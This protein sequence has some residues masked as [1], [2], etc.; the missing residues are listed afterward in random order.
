MKKIK[1]KQI[2]FGGT[3]NQYIKGNGELGELD[4]ISVG[5]GSTSSGASLPDG[6]Y[7]PNALQD[8]DGN[9]YG[10]VVIGNQVWLAENYRCTKLPTGTSI[11]NGSAAANGGR[12]LNSASIPYY[13]WKNNDPLTVDDYGLKYNFS[14]ISAGERS[15]TVPGQMKG[16]APSNWHIPSPEEYTTLLEYIKSKAEYN[17]TVKDGKYSTTVLAHPSSLG[18]QALLNTTEE[19]KEI[20]NATG[21]GFKEYMLLTS[22]L[23]MTIVGM[24]AQERVTVFYQG[25]G[26]SDGKRYNTIIGTEM[27]SALPTGF[28]EYLRIVSDFNPI[29]FR[30]WYVNQ[31]GTMQHHLG[32]DD[33][34]PDTLATL[35]IQTNGQTLETYDPVS[36]ENKVVNIVIPQSATDLGALP[37][38]T[39][40]A[41]SLDLSI[42]PSTFVMTGQ[43]YDQDNNA[44]GEPQLIDLPLESVVVDGTYDSQTGNII[45]TLQNGNTIEFP[46]TALVNGLQNVQPDWNQTDSTKDDYIK[47]KPTIPT[48]P[49]IPTVRTMNHEQLTDST[50]GDINIHDGFYFPNATQ[51]ADGNWYGA[52]VIGDQVWMGENLRTTKLPDGTPITNGSPS[53]NNGTL[54]YSVTEPRYYISDDDPDTIPVV[55]LEYNGKALLNG[56]TTSD[57]V[58]SGIQG[59]APNGWHIPSMGEYDQ[60]LNYVISQKRYL[61]AAPYNY[62]DPSSNYYQTNALNERLLFGSA[63]A[64][65]DAD[66]YNATGFNWQFITS[67]NSVKGSVLATTNTDSVNV[68]E[69][70]SEEQIS[71]CQTDGVTIEV[72]SGYLFA[73]DNNAQY[74]IHVRCVSNLTPIQFRN[75]YIA[76]YGSLQH[77]V[78]E[79]D[80]NDSNYVITITETISYNEQH[81]EI[82]TCTCDKTAEEIYNNAIAVNKTPSFVINTDS[83]Q[84][85][86]FLQQEFIFFGNTYLYYLYY[87]D[88]HSPLDGY[89]LYEITIRYNPTTSIGNSVHV[90]KTKHN[91]YAINDVDYSQLLATQSSKRSIYVHDG[92][93]YPNALQDR[94]GN[95]YGAVIIGNQ[96]W[97][98]ENLRTSKYADGTAIQS[99][100]TNSS[101]VTPYYYILDNDTPANGYRYNWAAIVRSSS[102]SNA[103]PSGVQGVAPNRCHIPSS[104]EWNELLQYLALNK[105]KFG[106]D[107]SKVLSAQLATYA[108]TYHQDSPYHH[109]EQNNTSG[110]TAIPAGFGAL[111]SG[112]TSM[113]YAGRACCFAT[114]TEGES[115]TMLTCFQNSLD[116][117][118]NY[119]F[120]LVEKTKDLGVSVRCIL[121]QTPM[122]FRAW[123]VETYGTM[124]H[125]LKDEILQSDWNQ[126][127]STKQDYIK[128]KPELPLVIEFTSTN[129]YST[130][131]NENLSCNKTAVE[132]LEA[133]LNKDSIIYKLNF[134]NGDYVTLTEASETFNTETQSSLTRYTITKR[135]FSQN[136][137]SESYIEV[138]LHIYI[139][140]NTSTNEY[141]VNTFYAIATYNTTTQVTVNNGSLNITVNSHSLLSFGANQSNNT[142]LDFTQGAGITLEKDTTNNSIVI[143]SESNHRVTSKDLILISQNNSTLYKYNVLCE[144]NDVQMSLVDLHDFSPNTSG[145]FYN[146]DNVYVWTKTANETG[147]Y[148]GLCHARSSDA[149]F[150]GKLTINDAINN[151]VISYY[152]G[153]I[154]DTPPYTT[155]TFVTNCSWNVIARLDTTSQTT[156]Y[157]IYAYVKIPDNF[158]GTISFTPLRRTIT[159]PPNPSNVQVGCFDYA[160][161]TT[162]VQDYF[163]KD[164][165]TGGTQNLDTVDVLLLDSPAPG[166]SGVTTPFGKYQCNII[167]DFGGTIAVNSKISDFVVNDFYLHSLEERVRSIVSLYSLLPSLP[168]PTVVDSGKILT[169]DSSGNYVL[170]SRQSNNISNQP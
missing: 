132:I 85:R 134:A 145:N 162:T 64:G 86:T 27:S 49:D 128:N 165:V 8:L 6:Y 156:N 163:W 94:D 46:I 59:I 66:K 7:F 32:D 125:H 11:A 13:Y 147:K 61:S 103:K 100:G 143:S 47:N 50:L 157:N 113:N 55:G 158:V 89:E 110:F 160:A 25:D 15:T 72:D 99:G 14:A 42:N 84:S 151:E 40:Y 58:P 3:E 115:N 140:K 124:Q 10:G 135:L 23:L 34:T 9:W 36:G 141:T 150:V 127:D 1:R 108:S 44:M 137:H 16:I 57:A 68:D 22:E 81:E 142:A 2:D 126:D 152:M 21:F 33:N 78:N 28:G 130:I 92:E 83:Y 37:G 26:A 51:D 87:S 161:G 18:T 29:Q 131:N 105:P 97:L 54:D 116:N 70:W 39:K 117:S 31:Y 122:Q 67:N 63:Y 166:T 101:T 148:I 104:E 17:V 167:G 74:G 76:Q 133:I 120:S 80:T 170:Q 60:L 82:S 107:N 155:F 144:L 69:T 102:S 146:N 138:L 98:G 112:N 123:Y 118:P 45:L 139:D 95:W 38:S 111:P 164:A 71:G 136:P 91:G 30:N 114:C 12:E 149:K 5:D 93:Y 56:D 75:W 4:D 153:I 79:N 53:A 52:V 106:Y 159:S 73:N 109:P 65:G 48:I 19:E 119:Q 88:I 43:L 35:S 62:Q 77:H 90:R 121:D 96:V 168:T 24:S 169:V 154:V 41:A 129:N 20:L